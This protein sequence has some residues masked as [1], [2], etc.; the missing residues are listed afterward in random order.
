MHK[1]LI[2][3]MLGMAAL[4]VVGTAAATAPEN[5]AR[6]TLSGAPREGTTL[7]TS[8]G[9]WANHPA[10]YAYAWQRCASDGTACSGIAGAT[11]STYTPVAADVGRTIRAVVTAVNADGRD[12]APSDPTDVV[13][14][15]NGPKLTDRP[16]VSGDETVGSELT[17]SNGSWTPTPTAYAY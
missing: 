16:A 10:S 1:R 17:V 14:S 6:P 4:V 15:K 2:V 9:I 8:N 5:L 12:L 13:A 11:K 7:S 3:G